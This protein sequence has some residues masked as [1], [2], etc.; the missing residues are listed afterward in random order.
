[1]T[2]TYT[3]TGLSALALTTTTALVGLGCSEPFDIGS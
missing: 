3:L 1:M 2:T